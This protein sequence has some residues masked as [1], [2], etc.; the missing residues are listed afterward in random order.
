MKAPVDWWQDFFSGLMV[1]FWNA[2]VPE[3]ATRADAAFLWRQLRLS[4]GSRVLDIACGAGRL[5]LVL[6]E[7]GA[8]VT[9]VDISAEFLE[10]A[11]RD[12]SARR[13]PV[14]FRRAEMRDLAGAGGCDAAFCFGNSFG[15]LDDE[16]NAAFL[17]AV[18]RALRPGGRFALDYGQSAESVFPRMSPRLEAEVG[19]YAFVEETRY[20][21]VSARVENRYTVSRDG[22]SETKLASQRVYLLRELSDLHERAG[23]SVRAIFGSPEDEP[24]ELG[25]ER[26]LLVAE[27]A[28]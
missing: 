12:A 14:D 2:A 17:Q 7:R 19:G 26:L 28:A 10:I 3:Q 18:S 1:G 13:L 8:A 9:G 6:A 15:F 23:L 25:S 5:A 22:R 16:G 4:P 27:K 24:F 20:D 11:R 21:P